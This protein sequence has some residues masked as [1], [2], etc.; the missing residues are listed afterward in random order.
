MVYTIDHSKAV[1]PLL[2]LLFVALWF[3]LCL[4]LCY[5]VLVFFSPLANR[6]LI[7]VFFVRL[8][9]LCYLVLSVSSSSWCL[10]GQ[11]FVIVAFPGLLPLFVV[12]VTY[13]LRFRVF[14]IC[15]GIKM[16]F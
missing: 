10:E 15:L 14:E 13:N 3:V 7:L 5:F 4:T 12:F 2:V 1:V 16:K 8:I 11:R 9:D 6:E